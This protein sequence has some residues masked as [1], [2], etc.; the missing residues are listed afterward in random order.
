MRRILHVIP[1]LSGGGAERQLSILA[2]RQ[3]ERGHD[4]HIALLRDDAPAAIRTSRVTLHPI[5]ASGNYDP[6]MALKLRAIVRRTNPE[7]LQTWL[8]LPDVMGGVVARLTGTPWILSERSEKAAYPPS[9]KHR[10]RASLA[11]RCSAI[12]ANSVGGREYWVEQGIDKHRIHVVPNAVVVPPASDV[13]ARIPENFANKPLILF[14]GRLSAEKN[15][16]VLADALAQALDRTN[17]VALL[18]GVGPLEGE[19]RARIDAAG[20]QE[21]IVLAGH[22][23]DVAQL[24]RQASVCVAVSVFE[25]NPN[26]VLEAM[27]V[28]CPLIVSDIPAYTRL[29]DARSAQIVPAEDSELIAAAIVSLLGDPHA[30]RER[31]RI[32]QSLVE[33]RT[34]DDL[35]DAHDN[36][37]ARIV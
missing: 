4:V 9:W 2:A 27:S 16:L 35:T 18:C 33:N 22:R 1:G 29:L 19:L 31:A 13:P 7:I 34:P 11:M 17:A 32:A 21:R 15:P 26:V 3:A 5:S 14:A 25:G 23:D 8:T 20:M 12:I 10:I 6:A 37:Y 28:G 24:M 30:A 36:V